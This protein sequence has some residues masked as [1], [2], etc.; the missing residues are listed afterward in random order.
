MS[1]IR[2]QNIGPLSDTG[3]VKLTHFMLIIGEQS[4]GKSTFLKILCF[5]KWVEKKIM[6]EGVSTIKKFETDFF[7]SRLMQFYK[8]S[9]EYFCEKSG[10]N[11]S[12]E[13]VDIQWSNGKNPKIS[14]K[15]NFELLRHNCKLSYIPAE[16]NLLSVIP[17]I[18]DKYRSS[19]FDSMFNFIMEFEEAN[20]I[21]TITNPLKLPVTKKVEY[22]HDKS[23]GDFIRLDNGK[24]DLQLR[25]S[26][27][28][29]QAAL[30]LAVIVHYL[31]K[32]AGEDAKR[33]PKMT[34][35]FNGG[36]ELSEKLGKYNYPQFFIEEPEQHLFPSSQAALVKDIVAEFNAAYKKTSVPGYVF[37]TTHS[38]YILT[39]LN[40]LLKAARA[41]KKD[42][43][44]TT[45]IIKEKYLLPIG[46]YSSY[47]VTP[48][49]TFKNMIDS[50][51]GLIKGEYLD[52]VSEKTENALNELNDV[53]YGNLD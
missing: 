38:P 1:T 32:V 13:I 43:Q 35:E 46:F 21:F 28:G 25:F 39:Q 33:S 27:S 7:I 40:V 8:F 23:L 30:P 12:S 26:S 20:K 50:E 16:R 22:F 24:K 17:Q 53:I 47:F 5:L 3:I 15:D 52:K 9:D 34:E 37:I 29:I 11:Y 2:I 36:F 44:S 4:V 48:K 18:D 49:G 41:Y 51:T 6:T 19:T 31:S 42:K 45:K 10:I 14:V